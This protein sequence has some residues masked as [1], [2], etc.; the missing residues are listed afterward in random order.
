MRGTNSCEHEEDV[1]SC[2]R[3]CDIVTRT[4]CKN[5]NKLLMQIVDALPIEKGMICNLKVQLDS[6]FS[7]K[8]KTRL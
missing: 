1:S 7:K 5:H 8:P 3:T 4:L 6:Q 2:Q